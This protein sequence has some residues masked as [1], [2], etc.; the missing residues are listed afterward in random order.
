M[1][2]VCTVC[3][4]PQRRAIDRALATGQGSKRAIAS[5]FGLDDAAV[6]RHAASHLSKRLALAE[7]AK[8][9]ADAGTILDRVTALERDAY[10]L[11]DQA[12]KSGDLVTALKAHD[13]LRRHIELLGRLAGALA[14][15]A[16]VTFCMSP[17]WLITRTKILQA[18]APY[19]EARLAVAAALSA[20]DV[21]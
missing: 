14:Q 1:P 7:T 4:S 6:K 5:R 2:R 13:V 9:V 12:K 11:L 15:E 8:D 17:G 3:T 21:A 18:L 20:D 10:T 19:P 16:T